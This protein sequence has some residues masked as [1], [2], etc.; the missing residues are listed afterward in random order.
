M[1][2]LMKAMLLTNSS[3]NIIESLTYS[4]LVK[5]EHRNLSH[6]KSFCSRKRAITPAET[7]WRWKKTY[8]L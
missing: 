6:L 1:A 2:D 5:R 7:S 3:P 8:S 4:H